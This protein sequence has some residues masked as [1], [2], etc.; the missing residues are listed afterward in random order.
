[1]GMF[2]PC[3]RCNV[4]ARLNKPM[5][6]KEYRRD[7]SRDINVVRVV[8]PKG[9]DVD[10]TIKT[11]RTEYAEESEAMQLERF[12]RFHQRRGLSMTKL[13]RGMRALMPAD[14][15]P[16]MFLPTPLNVADKGKQPWKELNATAGALMRAMLMLWKHE[17]TKF[18][19][20]AHWQDLPKVV[21]WH[22][23]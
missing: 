10:Q 5:S 18:E 16:H 1:M 20:R 12:C 11:V 21:S 9:I 13:Y 15:A 4:C 2:S 17:L 23:R 3:G 8:P 14:P 19:L 22:V 6:D 7:I